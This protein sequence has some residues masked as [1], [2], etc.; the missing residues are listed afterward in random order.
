MGTGK[1]ENLEREVLIPCGADTSRKGGESEA[2]QEWEMQF[3]DGRMLADTSA[4][5]NRL[6]DP[7]LI[8]IYNFSTM[9]S[10]SRGHGQ[11]LH[12][13]RGEKPG[14][15]WCFCN[16]NKPIAKNSLLCE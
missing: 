2:D 14:Q 10:L 4:V 1:E 13:K 16:E 11:C 12:T 3:P 8:A 6:S 5:S 15:K 7:C 9:I